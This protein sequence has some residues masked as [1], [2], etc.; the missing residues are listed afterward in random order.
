[1]TGHVRR[2]GRHLLNP[3]H[4]FASPGWWFASMVR[5]FFLILLIAPLSPA[6]PGEQKRVLL[7]MQEDLCCPVFRRIDENLHAT[8]RSGAPGGVLIY[9]EHMDLFHGRGFDPDTKK[10]GVGIGL[11]GMTERLRLVGGTLPVKSKVNCG[12]AI[13][14]EVPM[15]VPAKEVQEKANDTGN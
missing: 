13:I 4:H 5:A 2:V 1:M 12:T 9:S 3:V 7:L 15:A 6:Q 10:S 8:L 14:A 11:I